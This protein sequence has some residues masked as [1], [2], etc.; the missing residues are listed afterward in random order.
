MGNK[1]PKYCKPKAPVRQYLGR[2][3][4]WL[5]IMR[6]GSVMRCYDTLLERM[7]KLY[8]NYTG[9]EQFTMYDLMDYE[10][11]RAQEVAP[12][13][14]TK[15]M[16]MLYYFWR[17]LKED[18]GATPHNPAR[19]YRNWQATPRPKTSLTLE[20]TSRL[21]DACERLEDKLCILD[22]MQGGA[23]PKADTSQRRRINEA[24]SS[25]GLTKFNM[26]DM[27]YR[28][29]NRIHEGVIQ[30]YCDKVRKA[31]APEVKPKGNPLGAIELSTPDIRTTILD[32]NDY[33][34]VISGI[35]E[36]QPST[37]G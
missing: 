3:E 36:Q 28:F 1:K 18:A 5:L 32:G 15:E 7:L 14:V 27:K 16:H 13:S 8:P 9:W 2:F 17:W 23:V 20:D 25:I 33:L 31:L 24:A 11:L 26:V 22:V 29:T 4:S 21:I 12:L 6:S 19:A 34:T 10:K 30:G 35:N 37:E